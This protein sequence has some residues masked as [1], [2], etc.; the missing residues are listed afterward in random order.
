MSQKTVILTAVLFALIVVG[1]F[2]YA[3]LKNKEVKEQAGAI[4][5]SFIPV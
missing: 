3:S 4:L 1:M 2:V 5:S